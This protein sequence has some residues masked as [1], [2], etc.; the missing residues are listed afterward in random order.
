MTRDATAERVQ[1]LFHQA[2][3]LPVTERSALLAEACR[4]ND[5]LRQRIERLLEA[6][7]AAGSGEAWNRAALEN[8]ALAQRAA[9][10]PAIGEMAGPY[11]L[12][13]LIGIGGM[14]RV[15][16]AVRADAEFEKSVAVKRISA[17]FEAQPIA[18]RFRAERQ[19]LANLDHPNIARLIDGG[20][21]ADGM[22]YLIM[23]YIEGEPPGDYCDH[24]GFSVR[25]RLEL[26]RQ[27]CGAVQ[28]AHQ[29]MVVHRDL[30]PGNILV[31]ADG[32]PKLLDFGIA[33]VLSPQPGT[34]N[35]RTEAGLGLMTARY[36]SP[37]QVRGE[38]V[39]TASDVYSLGVILY[40]LLTGHSPYRNPNAPAHELLHSVCNQDPPRP[41]AY[42]RELRGDLDN[43]LLKALRKSPAE[44]YASADRFAEDI[45]LYLE[46]RPVAARGYTFPYVAAKFLRRNKTASAATAV[47]LGTLLASLIV[48]DRAR[49]RAEAR[50]N[51][52]RE[53]AHSVI[54]SYHDAI[55]QLP[56]STPVRKQMVKDAL[57]YL[58]KL[59]AQADTPDLE[60]EIVESYVRISRVQGGTY[61]SNLGDMPGAMASAQ[62]A[63]AEADKLLKADRSPESLSVA[64]DA[65][66]IQ[67]TLLFSAAKLQ[68]AA[69][70]YWRAV[71][72][73]QQVAAKKPD[74]IENG[75]E[76]TSLFSHLGDLMG[77]VSTQNLGQTQQSVALYQQA[78]D[79]I[80]RLSERFPANVDVAWERFEVLLPLSAAETGMGNPDRAQALL[81]QALAEIEKVVKASPE[82]TDARFELANT[83]N[84]LGSNL[85][86]ARKAAAALPHEEHSVAVVAALL[87]A[88]PQNALYAR[89]L[90]IAETQLAAALRGSGNMAAALEYNR[91]AL[92][93]ATNLSRTDPGDTD[94]RA[95][96]G[97]NE[98]KMAETLLA[99]G[100]AAAALSAAKQAETI[101]CAN[102]GRGN[103]YLET[104]CG[105]TL[106]VAG[107][108]QIALRQFE[109]AAIPLGQA[110]DLASS[111]LTRDP[112]NAIYRSDLARAESA[113]A[114]ALARAGRASEAKPAFA[115]AMQLWT[116]LRI[117]KSL[118]GEDAWRE[119]Q[120]AREFAAAQPPARTH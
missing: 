104:H 92:S 76:L 12:V 73:R 91:N 52:L 39:T 58:E 41:S 69:D 44:R 13:E 47:V 60:R 51:D 93:L 34:D 25:Q 108:A 55:E 84:R 72:L 96:V 118:T 30:K 102:P 97:I 117:K 79:T 29:R 80:G 67:A 54:F 36:A 19:I 82:N 107:S 71:A 49:A 35:A 16:R 2:A 9:G 66:N 89:S 59:S 20:V 119:A 14:G 100:D 98:R 4:G 70:F 22:P 6:D 114:I 23:E 103:L 81:L 10:D 85:L 63:V 56:G 53:L 42:R 116:E 31:T 77:G 61:G 37:E 115:H 26:F 95:D 57:V 65:Y 111:A 94:Y 46:G 1:E 17:G 48:V 7:Q 27:I 120:A 78:A 68:N 18:A 86:D 99:A 74:D 113:L 112:S 40:E 32:T 3:A 75:I 87:K 11:K 15:Y 8:E 28:Y 45:R 83:E 106:L 21:T 24:H 110:V 90:G 105:R 62:K 88:D 109:A 101:L 5:A 64:A 50:F 33:K 43:I 38:P